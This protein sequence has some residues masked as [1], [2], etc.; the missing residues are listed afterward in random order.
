LS[1]L[2]VLKRGYAIVMHSE[3]GEAVRRAEDVALGDPLHIR[4]KQGH[5]Q[6]RVT[7]VEP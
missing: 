3:S 6:A 1:P 2:G 4:L 5:L 7:E